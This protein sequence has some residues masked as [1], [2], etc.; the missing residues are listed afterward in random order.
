MAVQEDHDLADGTLLGPALDDLA[1]PLRS[2]ARQR[3][4][5][6]GFRLDDLEH[7]IAEGGDQLAGVNGAD[8]ADQTG[9][10]YFSRFCCK[11]LIKTKPP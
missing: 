10:R 9:G 11:V 7:G 4:Q 6:V 3:A 2:D 5:P 1:G 8:A